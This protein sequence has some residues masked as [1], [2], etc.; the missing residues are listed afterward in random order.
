MSMARCT[1]TGTLVGPGIWRKCLPVCRVIWGPYG[2]FRFAR[3][4]ISLLSGL[5]PCPSDAVNPWGTPPLPCNAKSGM[6]HILNSHEIDLWLRQ[7]PE[8]LGIRLKTAQLP[9]A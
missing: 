9:P 3:L 4:E 6:Q 5:V 1:R 8:T 7:E 2:V